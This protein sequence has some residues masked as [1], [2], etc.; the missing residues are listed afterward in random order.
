M[1]IQSRPGSWNWLLHSAHATWCSLGAFG[2]LLAAALCLALVWLIVTWG[3][4]RLGDGG[5]LGWLAD[6]RPAVLLAI[7]VSWSAPERRVTG[8]AVVDEGEHL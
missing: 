2:V 5:V 4:I 3:W 7:G 8:A 1:F 6:A